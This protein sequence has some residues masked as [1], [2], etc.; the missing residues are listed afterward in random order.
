MNNSRGDVRG[1]R[2]GR[3]RME[4]SN[5]VPHIS[6][7]KHLR[8]ERE[9]VLGGDTIDGTRS[10]YAIPKADIGLFESKKYQRT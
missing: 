4:N 10:G 6:T 7:A 9:A 1:S 5:Y 3:S 2:D 8:L